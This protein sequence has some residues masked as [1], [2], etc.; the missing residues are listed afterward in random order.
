MKKVFMVL[1]CQLFA[2][3]NYEWVDEI[4]NIDEK[5]FVYQEG[6]DA[7]L[8]LYTKSLFVNDVILSPD[9]EHLAFQSDSDDF[10][11]GIIIANLNKYLKDGL[12]K[13]TVA[14]LAID[15]PGSRDLGIRRLFLCNM[16]W[17]S[18]RHLLVE[19]C[20]KT[21]DFIQGEQYFSV[22]IY[23][24]YDLQTNEFRNFLYP[25]GELRRKVN[26]SFQDRYKPATFISRYDDNHI[27]VSVSENRRGFRFATLRKI[28]L[29]KEGTEPRGEDI[30]KSEVPCQYR[31]AYRTN[32]FCENPNIFVLNDKKEPVL[33][34][35]SNIDTVFAHAV[36]E[37][38]RKIDV[39]LEEYGLLGLKGSNLWLLGD[40]EGQ[41]QG[42]SILNINSGKITLVTPSDCS[43]LLEGYVSAN[44]TTPYA[45]GMECQGMKD[46]V[47]FNNG[48]D[49]QILTS[50]IRSFPDKT[51][52]LSSWSDDGMKALLKIKD[53][54][55]VTD[56]FLLNLEKNSLEFIVN[57]SNVPKNKL[58]KN[59]SYQFTASDGFV[60]YGYLTLPEGPIKKLFTYVHGGPHGPRDYDEYEPFEQYLASNGVAVLKVNFRGSG[61]YGKNYEESGYKEWGGKIM[62]DIAHATTDIQGKFDI[63]SKDT[64]IGGASFGGY[65][66]LTMAYK[67][68]QILDCVVGMMG[69]YDLN[70][71]RYGEDDSV[72]TRQDRYDEIMSDY[73]GEN[74]DQLND[75]SPINNVSKLDA[76]ILM[77]HGKQDFIAPIV[78]FD[79]LKEAL[80]VNDVEY[81]AFTMTRLGH[82]Y[83]AQED[84]YIHLPIMKNFILDQL[85]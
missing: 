36:Q 32:A 60:Y 75:F 47:T 39:D 22:G 52:E 34:F 30:F 49:A 62:D 55:T 70:M 64:C 65:A 48:R 2:S 1:L 15:E 17:A 12:S 11:Q 54:S 3:A 19:L 85:E 31:V 56:T 74:E 83:G 29:N 13:S 63:S 43:S 25:F 57:N 24:I 28:S 50:L 84:M 42:L 6:S 26:N 59:K 16:T 38:N 23:K 76:R 44:Q 10:T 68:P 73:L 80:D 41:T 69:V 71:L 53:S 78:H 61:G 37:D 58:Y 27:L 40:P 7:N 77:W 20:G 18:K 4:I 8:E 33:T 14:K 72:Y 67:Y 46:I 45:V 81:Q 79:N 9:G 82:T 5:N 21:T 51:V 66:A 35:S